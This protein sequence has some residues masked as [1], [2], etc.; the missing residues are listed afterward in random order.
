MPPE[1]P[2]T[3]KANVP[4]VVIGLPATEISPPVNVS[5]TDVTV[6]PIA[7]NKTPESLTFPDPSEIST[8][9][10]GAA[11]RFAL[12]VAAVVVLPDPETVT[13]PVV[14]IGP[15]VAMPAV[16]TLVTPPPPPPLVPVTS[17]RLSINE[18]IPVLL[19]T[20]VAIE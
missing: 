6:P 13:V 2:A 16:P 4:L 1:V 7:D 10:F 9:P 19:V 12:A 18:T 11:A 15:P 3:V 14:V 17:G 5:A 8:S 20:T